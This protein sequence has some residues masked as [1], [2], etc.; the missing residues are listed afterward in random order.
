MASEYKDTFRGTAW[1]YARF[2]EGYPVEFFD[3]VK[4][5]FGLSKNDRVLDIGCGTG[6]IAIPISPFVREVV[7]MDPEPE[8][9]AEGKE[10]ARM[11]GAKNIFWIEGGSEDLP[12]M[13]ETL[14]RF[15]LV[16]MGNSFHW[17]DRNRILDEFF[18]ITT[19]RGGIVITGSNNIWKIWSGDQNDWQSTVKDI[20][21]KWLGEK[22][23]AGSGFFQVIPRR[24]EE[25]VRESKFKNTEIWTYHWT[26]SLSLD[27]VIGNLYS[28]SW[29]NPD[30]LGNNKEEFEK[31]LREAL[32]NVNASGTYAAEGDI[33][34]ILAWK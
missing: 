34:A 19:D 20:I 4:S 14:G 24:H 10:Q 29:A 7:A 16:T 18:K 17:M 23:R 25:Y 27:E 6:Q 15:K 32:I 8:M 12:R 2:R 33:E 3:M 21:R 1:Y 28:T 9:I 13:E 26:L 31:E 22:R 11:R 30:V 5:K